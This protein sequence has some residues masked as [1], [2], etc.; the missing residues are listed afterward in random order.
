VQL[1]ISALPAVQGAVA[2]ILPIMTTWMGCLTDIA[3]VI[4]PPLTTVVG[5]L[6][7][8][9]ST[10]F[11]RIKSIV[12]TVWDVV[13]PILEGMAT[14]LNLIEGPLTKIA[15]LFFGDDANAPG[16]ATV[17]KTP[18]ASTTPG[19]PGLPAPGAPGSP[20]PAP[21]MSAGDAQRARRG[22]RGV[23]QVGPPVAPGADWDATAQGESNGNWQA[24]TGNGFYGGLQFTQSTWDQFKPAGAPA[25]A[26][27]A[28]KEQQI[29]AAEATLK[30]QGPGA[31]P[32]TFVPA[33]AAA[34]M[35][36][37]PVVS[38]PAMSAYTPTA[39]V[40]GDAVFNG[41]HTED[42]HGALVPNAENLKGIIEQSFPGVN[43]GGYRAPDGFNEH[44]S[45][46]ALDI[47]VGGNKALGDQINQ[48]LLQNADALGVQYDLWQQ[49]QW[50]PDGS[51]SAMEDRGDAT[52]NHR[53]HVHARVRP[54]SATPGTTSMAASATPGM[55]T[56]QP[57]NPMY[58]AL[59]PNI[60]AGQ[61][62]SSKGGD[63][64]GNQL[65]QD[66][67][68]GM[69]E[70]LGLD[71]SI[72]KDPANFGLVK[73]MKGLMGLKFADNGQGGGG[74]GGG[75]APGGG[76]GGDITSFMTSFIPQPFGDLKVGSPQDAPGQFMP[77]NPGSNGTGGIV[78][79]PMAPTGA[80]GPG[81][82]PM[83][84]AGAN[85]DLSGSTFG[86]S[87]TEVS[88]QIYQGAIQ[89]IRQP[90]RNIP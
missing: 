46:E 12:T 38:A 6:A 36:T 2:T 88:D 29:A 39:A 55:P 58:V 67:L 68:G 70:I 57:T 33:P 52:A 27:L 40:P 54:G 13:G 7:T 23:G 49:T 81:N 73:I 61:Q 31:W 24:N 53:D 43:V 62:A 26:D 15:E 51:S 75:G 65:G 83:H 50:N 18:G 37:A 35:P 72:F 78:G 89:S 3:K 25:R 19:V 10:S 84:Q 5:A 11:D 79:N 4:I 48:F 74:G 82:Y 86:Y 9:F 28:T 66:I 47:M 56:G 45:G 59:S 21:G 42:T 34:A 14:K 30:A 1:A 44:S 69:G 17:A 63:T 90:L 76:G 85:V 64:G 22:E 41:Q 71:G 32:N 60:P 8:T 16:G 87:K 80:P 77:S 20:F